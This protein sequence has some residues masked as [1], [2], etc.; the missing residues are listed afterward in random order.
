[1]ENNFYV[2]AEEFEKS[3]VE[4]YKR[5]SEIIS[6][7]LSKKTFIFLAK[8][9]E[10]HVKFIKSLR[11]AGESAAKVPED[12]TKK[13]F[14][15]NFKKQKLDKVP[16]KGDLADLSILRMAYL[17]EKDFYEFY[18]RAYENSSSEKDKAVLLMLRNWEKGHLELV[19]KLMGDIFERSGL[20]AGFYPL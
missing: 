4:F 7:A 8:M 6:D 1:M 9:E 11:A 3:G 10:E 5:N 15:E 13:F 17:I 20:E 14:E 2:I 18:N 16:A 19:K 12:D